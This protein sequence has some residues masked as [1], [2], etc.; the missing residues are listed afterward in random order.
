ME[1]KEAISKLGTRPQGGSLK[2][3]FKNKNSD[4]VFPPCPMLYALCLESSNPSILSVFR[5]LL[6]GILA[7]YNVWSNGIVFALHRVTNEQMHHKG[8]GLR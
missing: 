1:S 5:Q 2:D 4:C 3:N 7:T 6:I 8:L